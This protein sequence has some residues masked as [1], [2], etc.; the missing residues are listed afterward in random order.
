MW[1]MHPLKYNCTAAPVVPFNVFFFSFSFIDTVSN[2][3]ACETGLSLL[4]Y[5]SS[6][7]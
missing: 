7:H 1:H 5:L 6:L 2:S 3:L 4:D